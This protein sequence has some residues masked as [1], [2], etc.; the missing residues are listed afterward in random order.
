[1][2]FYE[3]QGKK[4]LAEYGIPIPK[5]EVAESPQEARRIAERLGSRRIAAKVQVKAGGRGRGGG[6]AVLDS[7]EEVESWAA[8]VLGKEFSTYQMGKATER[9]ERVLIEEGVDIKG[10]LYLGVTLDRRRGR[11]VVIGSSEGGVEIEEVARRNPERVVKEEADP[12]FGLLPFQA[13]RMAYKMGLGGAGISEWVKITMGLFKAATEK[14]MLLAEINPLALKEG[15]R[16]VALDAKVEIDDNALRRHPEFQEMATGPEDPLEA[17]AKK[18]NLNY[19]KMKGDV[20]CLVN[21]AGLAMAT[22]DL[23]KLAGGEPANFLDVGGGAT[24]EMVREGLKIVHADPDVKLI[25]I[26]IFGGILRC[27]TLANGVIEA[28]KEIT[29]TKPI[30]VRLEGTNVEEGRRLLDSSGLDLITVG[31]MAEATERIVQML[32]EG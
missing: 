32:K 1:M 24:V 23:I 7:P 4:V 22:M 28:S 5:G 21:G 17:W 12:A 27:D 9:V 18:Y 19:I 25:F 29:L 3:F 30:V 14:E 20:G 6:I 26:N 10:E 11:L 31:T 8:G 16:F 13:R 15:D 2:R